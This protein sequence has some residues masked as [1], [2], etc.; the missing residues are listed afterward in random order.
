LSTHIHTQVD[1]LFDAVEGHTRDDP[2]YILW[3][4]IKKYLYEHELWTLF[5]PTCIERRSCDDNTSDDDRNTKR[6]TVDAQYIHDIMHRDC[7][8]SSKDNHKEEVMTVVFAG[9]ANKN[10][11]VRD[12]QGVFEACKWW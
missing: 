6:R 3:G 11:K 4:E 1:A 12:S 5:D 2:G 7:L 9:R 10:A 8:S